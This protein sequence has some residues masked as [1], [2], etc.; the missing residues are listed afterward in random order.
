MFLLSITGESTSAALTPTAAGVH[1]SNYGGYA[2]ID[3]AGASSG[4]SCI[5]FTTVGTD[6]KGRFVYRNSSSQFEWSIADSFTAKMTLKSAGLYLGATLVFA[7]DKRLQFN[8]KPLV[9][10]L[11][12]IGKLEP[13]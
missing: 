11:D 2:F 13:V 6:M 4:G 12:I 5:D 9:N 7:S 3:L 10:A 1:L 8:E